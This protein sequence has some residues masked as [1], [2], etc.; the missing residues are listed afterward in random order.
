M[1]ANILLQSCMELESKEYEKTVGPN[2]ERMVW[3]IR[4]DGTS[5]KA[6]NGISI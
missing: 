4:V 2:K 3:R 6:K 1:M 5:N